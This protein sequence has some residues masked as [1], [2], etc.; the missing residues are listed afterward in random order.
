ML[1][2]CAHW[3]SSCLQQDIVIKHHESD[4]KREFVRD[5]ATTIRLIATYCV[6][7]DQENQTRQREV[8][9]HAEIQVLLSIAAA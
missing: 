1:A 4:T 8:L 3:W 7:L 6:N 9:A 2:S 5:R